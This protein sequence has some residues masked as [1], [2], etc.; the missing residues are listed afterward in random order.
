MSHGFET[1]IVNWLVSLAAKMNI[2]ILGNVYT[3]DDD[4]EDKINTIIEGK[5]MAQNASYFAFTA[6]PKNKT[7]EMFGEIITDENGNPILNEDGTKRAKP[8]DV[9][10]MKQAIEEK[11]ILDVLKYYT[12]VLDFIN[13][14]ADIQ[15]SFER[16]YKTTVLSGETDANKLNDLI[17]N[18]EPM[19]V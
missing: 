5:K 17:D 7:L 11:F 19:Q 10:T 13:N 3:D 18:M 16:Y 15:K 6:T 14:P 9:Y 8:H 12:F 1:L 2:V 4:F